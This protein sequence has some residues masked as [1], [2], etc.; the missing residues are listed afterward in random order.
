[1]KR[2]SASFLVCAL[3]VIALEMQGRVARKPK[4]MKDRLL[5]MA[6]RGDPRP[7]DHTLLGRALRELTTEP[8]PAEYSR[9]EVDLINRGVD[10]KDEA[11]ITFH[12]DLVIDYATDGQQFD[13]IAR[14]VLMVY[15]REDNSYRY[16]EFRVTGD[17][18]RCA[19]QQH[20][21]SQDLTDHLGTSAIRRT[22]LRYT[23]NV[24]TNLLK[25]AELDAR[26][27]FDA[28]N[29]ITV[30]VGEAYLPHPVF[31][32]GLPLHPQFVYLDEW[33]GW[34]D[35]LGSRSSGRMT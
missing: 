35:F 13:G 12:C 21:A 15:Q 33:C 31:R 2:I 6:R 14:S 16:R 26:F 34:R 1:M 29:S 4:L 30:P 7:A 24:A 27:M 18:A 17:G 5:E 3:R 23:G 20:L 28:E 8:E 19:L 22:K 9:A 25:M 11:A 10:E 32:P